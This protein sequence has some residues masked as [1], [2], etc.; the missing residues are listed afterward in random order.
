[1]SEFAALDWRGRRVQIEYA[2]IPAPEPHQAKTPLIVFL[3]EGLL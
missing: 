3:H 1:M 2:W